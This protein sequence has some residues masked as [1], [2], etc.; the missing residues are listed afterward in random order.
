MSKKQSEQEPLILEY[1]LFDLPTAQH[2]AGLAGLLVMVESMKSRG[3]TAFPAVTAITD[4]SA[5]ISFTKQSFQALFDDLYD[6]TVLEVDSRKKWANQQPKRTYEVEIVDLKGNQKK[7]IRYVYD[8]TRPNGAFLEALYPDHDGLWLNLWR[9]M[10]W[11]SLRGIPKTRLVYTERLTK[12]SSAQGIDL[13]KS[14]QQATTLRKKGEIKTQ[15]I[16]SS[17]YIGGQDIN[18]EKVSF[19]GR[20]EQN[21]LLHFWTIVTCVFVPRFYSRDGTA[22]QSGYVLAIP[23]P[24]D[25]SS[26]VEDVTALLRSLQTEKSGGRPRTALIDLPEE[27]GLEYLYHLSRHR[28]QRTEVGYSLA[29]LELYHLEK[30]GNNIR[31]LQSSR[32][33]PDSRLVA[34]YEPLR[35]ICRNPFF[36][37]QRLRN[38]L[39][40]NTW[41]NGF[42]VVFGPYPWEFFVH[43]DG[44][45]P[46]TFPFFGWDVKRT[47]SSIE[48]DLKSIGGDKPMT[49][50]DLDDALAVRIYDLIRWYVNQRTQD[51]S[52]LK[53]SDFK[54][55]TDE[56]G[57]VVYPERYRE[58]RQKV[59]SDA[60]LAMRSRREKDFI[61][62]F[63]G[64][65]CSVPQFLPRTE[66]LAVSNAL[67]NDWSRV[68]DLSML[69]LSAESYIGESQT[70]K[71]EDE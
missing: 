38:L 42:T 22:S 47:F 46:S 32:I 63:I 56:K 57:R 55:K 18:A 29:A 36:K 39:T 11:D 45:T 37:S 10:V 50:K 48:R 21:L 4:R 23:E 70:G 66:Y 35:R 59:C 26:F 71:G 30:Q 53:Y 7:E 68:K 33:L 12:Q 64:T 1:N 19:R 28:V 52:G 5:T 34:L 49:E 13:W 25:L 17:I 40:G 27:G 54:D 20:I 9:D 43:R 15:G 69:A 44:E 62:Y 41:H 58:A 61:E 3:L 8:V 67:I 14:L 31:A 60:F 24:S 65:I 51:K 2:K 6:A 16:A